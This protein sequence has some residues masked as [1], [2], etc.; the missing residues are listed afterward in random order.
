MLRRP[1]RPSE[2]VASLTEVTSVD[3]PAQPS[4]PQGQLALSAFT[5][6][7][8]VVWHDAR[9]RRVGR[10]VRVIASGPRRGQAEVA[11]GGTL[12]PEQVLRVPLERLRP[13]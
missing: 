12:M 3:R 13:A 4:P 11:I 8:A 1:R 5:P 6:G 9:G 2:G 7:E 10:F